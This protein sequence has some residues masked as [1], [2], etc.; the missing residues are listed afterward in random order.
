MIAFRDA[1]KTGPVS[2]RGSP[3]SELNAFR[4]AVK[5]GDSRAKNGARS[6]S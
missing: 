3:Q 6:P 5:T 2:E 4:N 1:V